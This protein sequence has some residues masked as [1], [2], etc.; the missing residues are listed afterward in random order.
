MTDSSVT[1][2]NQNHSDIRDE[3]ARDNDPLFE[4]SRIFGFDEQSEQKNIQETQAEPSMDAEISL[5][6]ELMAGFDADFAADFAAE[7]APQPQTSAYSEDR[8]QAESENRFVHQTAERFTGYA[9]LQRAYA[10]AEPTRDAAVQ[11]PDYAQDTPQYYEEP[12]DYAAVQ[13]T[14]AP[15]ENDYYATD[16]SAEQVPAFAEPQQDTNTDYFASLQNELN[17]SFAADAYQQP[18]AA[19]PNYSDDLPEL[20]IDLPDLTEAGREPHPEFANGD[21][22]TTFIEPQDYAAAGTA[23][24]QSQAEVSLED[25]LAFLLHDEAPA[26]PAVQPVAP[27]YTDVAAQ[28][29]APFYDNTPTQPEIYDYAPAQQQSAA[30]GDTDFS[31]LFDAPEMDVAPVVANFDAQAEQEYPA[32]TQPSRDYAQID[33][34]FFDAPDLSRLPNHKVSAQ[35]RWEEPETDKSAA[36][37]SFADLFSAASQPEPAQDTAYGVEADL[38]SS[39]EQQVDDF[40]ISDDFFSDKDQQSF[41]QTASEP[42]PVA[43]LAPNAVRGYSSY[44]FGAATPAANTGATPVSEQAPVA[45]A[46]SVASVA[47]TGYAAD[48]FMAAPTQHGDYEVG[49]QNDAV[50]NDAVAEK[51]PDDFFSNDDFDFSFEEEIEAAADFSLS[52]NTQPLQEE[53]P[54]YQPVPASIAKPSE[55]APEIET[56]TV[57]EN[58]VDQ[59]QTFDLP[60]VGYDDEKNEAGLNS[61]ESEFAEIFSTISV[62][63]TAVPDTTSEADKAFEDILA[64]NFADY[65]VPADNSVNDAASAAETDFADL[66]MAAGAAGLAAAAAAGVSQRNFTSQPQSD[67]SGKATQDDYYNHWAAQGAQTNDFDTYNLSEN[68]ARD[69]A[70]YEETHREQENP[71][72]K[73]ALWASVAAA[74]LLVAGGGYYL[75]KSGGV[76]GGEPAVLRADSQP[77]KMQPENPGGTV[78]PNQDKAVYDQVSG[79][80]PV[81][82]EQKTLINTEEEPVDVGLLQGQDAEQ[83]RL[84]SDAQDNTPAAQ[85]AE[86]DRELITPRTVKTMVVRADGTIVQGAAPAPKPATSDD[87]LDEA[88]RLIAKSA[89]PERL[90]AEK[91]V[92]PAQNAAAPRVVQ[93]QTFTASGEQVKPREVAAAPVVQPRPAPSQPQPA[94]QVAA[95][96]A[97]QSANVPAGTWFIQVASQPSA[98]LAQKSYA[99]L[100]SRYNNII[101]GRGVDIKKA[102]IPGKGTYYRVRI[103]A[104]SKADAAA[105]CGRLKSAGGSC[106]PTL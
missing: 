16:Y 60:D 72:R 88:S 55:P 19:Q 56:V 18:A 54:E 86:A 99:N 52:E 81:A 77:V 68:F 47:A 73:P 43:P 20:D 11:Q 39:Q 28:P 79:T 5:E 32:N 12:A 78:V 89:V 45:A 17:D 15:A 91:P 9:P 83:D 25:E 106:F 95:A 102:D 31:P 100:T 51:N 6:R 27:V 62:S 59:T 34:E 82:P 24:V 66:G 101:G 61:L 22:D 23:Q 37:S 87:G 4:L 65:Q 38:K 105:M 84:M 35:P 44:K 26:E 46:A 42:E 74:V 92:T 76:V 13:Q 93:T 75:L 90:P 71:L 85:Q 69:D 2:R 49:G 50:I 8:Y 96:P 94:Q 80:K 14:A 57:A 98:D 10:E 40:S 41:A 7:P 21:L 33:D 58:R 29:A 1:S 64:D 67:A 3:S 70:D 53:L 36:A 97:T 103:P 30:A 63:D 104:G 48:D